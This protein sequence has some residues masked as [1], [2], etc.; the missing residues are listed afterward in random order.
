[1]GNA[2]IHQIQ[3]LLTYFFKSI[4]ATQ[5]NLQWLCKSLSKTLVNSHFRYSLMPYN[6]VLF[7][8]NDFQQLLSTFPMPGT[9]S[10]LYV[11]KPG[12]FPGSSGKDSPVCRRLQQ[13]GSTPG[14][15][16][17]PGIGY[18]N[19]LQCSHGQKRLVGYSSWG[20]KQQT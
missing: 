12:A 5:G 17:S 20:C 19:R 18:G 10:V 8:F 15:G 7:I 1:M 16:R 3:K 13:H 2:T 9:V 14:M 4:H 11:N 6:S